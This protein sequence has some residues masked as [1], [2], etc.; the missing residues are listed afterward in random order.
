MRTATLKLQRSINQV[1]VVDFD[2]TL[3]ADMLQY[4]GGLYQ[5]KVG[6]ALRGTCRGCAFESTMDCGVI[7]GA[8][9]CVELKHLDKVWIKLEKEKEIE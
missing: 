5:L 7:T 9:L 8:A 1:M 6:T 3:P 4:K 2:V